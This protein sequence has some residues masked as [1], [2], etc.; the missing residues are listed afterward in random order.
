MLKDLF[1]YLNEGTLY[2]GL[3]I[4]ENQ[5]GLS[6]YVL[7]I[8]RKKQELFIAREETH[9]SL[10]EAGNQLKKNAPVFVVVNSSQVLTKIIEPSKSASD[11]VLV[12]N[13]FPNLDFKT[14]YYELTRSITGSPISICQKVIVDKF[15]NRLH[16]LKVNV[17]HFSLGISAITSITDYLHDGIISVS[18]SQLLLKDKTLVKVTPLST[19]ENQKSSEYNI[20]GILVKSYFLLSFS[21][22]LRHLLKRDDSVSNFSD[23]TFDLKK[24]FKNRRYFMVLLRAS[25]LITLAILLVNFLIYN[26]YF[27]K[28]NRLQETVGINNT[29]KNQLIKLR[30]EVLKKEDRVQAIFSTS[31]SRSS[32]IMNELVKK[33]PFSI[34]LSDFRYQP[35]IKPLRETKEVEVLYYT[36]IVSGQARES[37]EYYEWVEELEEQSWIEKIETIDYDYANDNTSNF[38]LK[39]EFNEEWN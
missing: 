12:H 24:E 34:I 9:K 10:E 28:V 6:F 27:G 18:N 5:A 39:I 7:E 17:V 13:A 1:T 11:E 33:M 35:L 4:S 31:N 15:L 22:I 23:Y 30:K 16:A 32:F 20:N 14:F 8:Q 3:E 2:Y 38:A 21:T 29:N 37:K 26:H 36:M 19:E 25:L